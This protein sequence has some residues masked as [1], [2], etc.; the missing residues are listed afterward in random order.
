[1]SFLMVGIGGFFGAIARYVSHSWMRFQFG[2]EL[3][4]GT[5]FINVVGC[6]FAGIVIVFVERSVP[7]HR[8]LLLLGMTGFLA[9]YT[10]FSTFGVETIDLMQSKNFSWALLNIFANLLGGLLAVV[11]GRTFAAWVS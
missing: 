9:S 3:P 4:L 5:L 10:T 8:Q 11:A 2:N 7:L 6:F 1:M